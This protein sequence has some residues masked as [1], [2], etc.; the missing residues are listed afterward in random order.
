MGRR[1]AAAGDQDVG[2]VA[3]QRAS[4]TG[5]PPPRRRAG[6]ARRVSGA[7]VVVLDGR[8]AQADLVVEL[9]RAED[10]V[11]RQ[12]VV[13]VHA[14]GLAHA[15]LRAE[16]DQ[17]RALVAGHPVDEEPG[18]LERLAAARDL[19]LGQEAHGSVALTMP[20]VGVAADRSSR[21]MIVA[22]TPSTG[23]TWSLPSRR[24]RSYVADVG[25]LG[26]QRVE[27]RPRSTVP[28]RAMSTL[29]I[30]NVVVS[31]WAGSSSPRGLVAERP[32]S[33]TRR[34]RPRHR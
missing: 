9:P 5:C 23:V 25:G 28:R 2:R 24:G 3:R 26:H 29:A 13:P 4:R 31:V 10:V 8:A 14:A 21:V 18:V 1:E 6:T 16:R 11:A 15:D 19:G 22:I 30:R 33:G 12:P 27:C 32:R 17:R 20:T 34:R 7:A